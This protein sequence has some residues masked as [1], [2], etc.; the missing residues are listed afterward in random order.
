MVR[1]GIAVEHV[2]HNI[3]IYMLM[4]TFGKDTTQ[5][6]EMTQNQMSMLNHVK[7]TFV[8]CFVSCYYMCKPLIYIIS[9]S[10]MY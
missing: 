6:V 4:G 5:I 3:Q 10:R 9:F 8:A 2:Q 1:D 7:N